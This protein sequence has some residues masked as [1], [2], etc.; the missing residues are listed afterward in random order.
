ML[1][2]EELRQIAAAVQW[3]GHF[4]PMDCQIGGPS[5]STIRD[6]TNSLERIGVPVFH[7]RATRERIGVEKSQ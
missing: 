7:S 4:A 2:Q 6:A 1:T 3:A 5:L